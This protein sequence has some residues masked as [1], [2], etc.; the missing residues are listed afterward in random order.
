MRVEKH[1]MHVELNSDPPL[2][3]QRQASITIHG[4]TKTK[5]HCVL[6]YNKYKCGNINIK[7]MCLIECFSRGL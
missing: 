3:F 4:N 6:L 1:Q 7:S 2:R 5:G